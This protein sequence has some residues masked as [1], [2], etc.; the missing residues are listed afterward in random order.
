MANINYPWPRSDRR[1]ARVSGPF[2]ATVSEL[3][4]LSES[5]DLILTKQGFRL[6]SFRGNTLLGYGE[7]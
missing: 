5:C 1:K 2:R 4:R 6:R 7:F 3:T